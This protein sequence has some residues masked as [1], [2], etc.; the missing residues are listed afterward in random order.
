ML[1]GASADTLV[2]SARTAGGQRDRQ[3]ITLFLVDAKARGVTLS[4][5]RTVDGLRAADVGLDGVHVGAEAVL[6]AVDGGYA[7][8]EAG[9][10][11][12]AAALC[13][14]AVGRDRSAQRGDARV[15][16]DAPAVRPA[17]RPAS[18]PC[19]TARSTC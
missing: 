12:G 6:G 2:V 14:E 3:G 19:S 9:A 5:A 7:T 16:Q 11:L 17:D 18:R 10:D 1:H 8:L 15:P 4:D 13:A